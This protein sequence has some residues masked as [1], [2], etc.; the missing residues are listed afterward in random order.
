M[1]GR[2]DHLCP[3][4]FACPNWQVSV[5]TNSNSPAPH[6][7]YLI[8]GGD[9]HE[10][11]VVAGNVARAAGTAYR[12]V[13]LDDI[14]AP[15]HRCAAIAAFRQ[16][17]SAE[18]PARSVVLVESADNLFQDSSADPSCA[19]CEAVDDEEPGEFLRRTGRTFLLAVDAPPNPAAWGGWRPDV[20]VYLAH[21]GAAPAANP[22]SGRLHVRVGSAGLHTAAR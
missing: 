2:A 20:V 22:A 4:D 5:L 19:R 18:D 10:R 15:G 11:G 12:Q 3:L 9:H 1:P 14:A 8:I 13:R 16:A 17:I 6:R 7:T 21:A